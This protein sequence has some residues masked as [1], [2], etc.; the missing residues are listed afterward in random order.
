[1]KKGG[2]G[3]QPVRLIGDSLTTQKKEMGTMK[4]KGKK[5]LV[6]LCAITCIMLLLAA[7]LLAEKK[8][9]VGFP[10]P[11]SG[12]RAGWGE[13][14]MQG[15]VLGVED[16]NAA[17]GVLG[18]QVELIKGDV[19]AMEPGTV[20]SVVRKLLTR[21]KVDFMLTG[22][23]SPTLVEYPVIQQFKM[24]YLIFAYAPSHERVMNENPGK[25]T[26]THDCVSSYDQ[27]RVQ[28]ADVVAKYEKEGKFQPINHKIAVIKSQNDYSKFCGDGLKA[29]FESRGW[30]T[31]VD[32]TI[33]FGGRFTEFSPILAKIRR[34]VPSVI[35]YTDYTSSNAASFVLDFLQDPT[36][37][38]LYLQATPSYP[39]FK[40]I[41][42]GRQSGVFWTYPDPLI[43]PKASGY[44]AKFQKRWNKRP[45]PYGV[46]NYDLVGIM[47]EAMKRAGDPF[48]RVAVN[49][50]LLA[51]DFSYEGIA[52]RYE[53]GPML[54]AKHGPGLIEFA[55]KQEWDGGSNIIIPW[56]YQKVGF[57][58]PP[59][60]AKGLAKY[61][62]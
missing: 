25:Y 37:S 22:A 48:D 4:D 7:P 58:I 50:A 8:I 61:G 40:D 23:A 18:H 11:L 38:L 42:K 60:Y 20:L 29:T 36:P 43:G 59:W 14:M 21:D 55:T 2:D 32:E 54:L 53:F 30:E 41:M 62:K 39:D 19:E 46:Y 45:D 10:A 17:G 24:P 15:T 47:T 9:K 12:P 57:Q 5:T 49:D 3:E 6:F 31:V 28:F 26:Y 33:P 56:A 44:V 16:L 1:L 13:S 51:K 35:I 52:G 34:S 27:Y